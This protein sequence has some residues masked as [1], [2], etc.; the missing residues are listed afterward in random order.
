MKARPRLLIKAVALV[1]SLWDAMSRVKRKHLAI[2]VT[3]AVN[4]VDFTIF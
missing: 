2:A 1:K 4:A 3:A